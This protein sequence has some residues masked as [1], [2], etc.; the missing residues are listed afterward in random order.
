[1]RWYGRPRDISN[2]QQVKP[3]LAS[4][5]AADHPDQLRLQAYLDDA[6]ALL[7]HSRVEGPWTLRLDVGLPTARDL[8]DGADLDNYAF[9]L[10]SRINDPDLVSVW[11]TKQHNEQSFV[12][13]EQ[14]SEQHQPATSVLVVRTTASASTVAYKEQIHAAIVRAA[15]LPAGPVSLEL[16]FV[17]GPRRNWLNLWKP[18]IDSLD[19]LLGRTHPDRAWHPRDG[20]IVELGMHVSVDPAAGNEVTVGIAAAQMRLEESEAS[21]VLRAAAVSNGWQVLIENGKYPRDI[22]QLPDRSTSIE[23]LWGGAGVLMAS[24]FGDGILSSSIWRHE[25]P[26]TKT[27]RVLSALIRQTAEFP[28]EPEYDEPLIDRIR[29]PNPGR[30]VFRLMRTEIEQIL[31]AHPRTRYAKVLIGM[32][33]GLTDTE[34]SEASI[35]AGQPI[36]ADS[37]AAVRKLVRL[38]LDDELVPAP[39]DAA[40]QAGIYRELL[41]YTRSP[42]LTQHIN[43][44][45]AQ[46]RALDPEILLTPLGH[47]HLGA[48]DPW[49]Q[50]KPEEPCPECF[51]VHAGEC[52]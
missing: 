18:T 20:R 6:E 42:E 49:K 9:P 48:N 26:E 17:V 7:A 2:L 22:Y 12:R 25:D 47:V 21:S 50:E 4:W 35:K 11:C 36:K 28:P 39:S 14:A 16:S 44:K 38:S 45:L 29:Q 19:P 1:M 34:M 32:R 52:P 5:D 46:L 13:V 37:I 27:E 31:I 24:A 8:L 51:M 3:R 33:A 41:N 10:A 30:E 23:V 43:T 40:A 15:E